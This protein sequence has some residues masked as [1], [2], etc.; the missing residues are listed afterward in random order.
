[1]ASKVSDVSIQGGSMPGSTEILLGDKSVDANDL[2]ADETVRRPSSE[3][4]VVVPD[5]ITLN[6]DPYKNW[7]V[8]VGNK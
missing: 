6:I 2:Q 8:M 4:H 5:H 1:M 7:I 3:L